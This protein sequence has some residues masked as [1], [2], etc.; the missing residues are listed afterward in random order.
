MTS[1]RYTA[2]EIRTRLRIASREY[3]VSSSSASTPEESGQLPTTPFDSL[4]SLKELGLV[5]ANDP[6]LPQ[7]CTYTVQGWPSQPNILMIPS[8]N[9]STRFVMNFPFGTAIVWV[10]VI[11]RAVIPASLQKKVLELAHEGHMGIKTVHN[12]VVVVRLTDF[13]A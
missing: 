4:I 9:L 11:A 5:S 10:E 6:L 1:S 8:S 3:L 13:R 2:Q 12:T 7:V